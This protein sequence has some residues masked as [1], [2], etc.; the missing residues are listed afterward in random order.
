MKRIVFY[1][2]DLDGHCAGALAYRH[3]K[4][5]KDIDI[6]LI[7]INYG[8]SFPWNKIDED[9][10]VWMVDFCL[11][12]FDQM[13]RLKEEAGDL[14]WID[15]H[16]KGSIIDAD[17]AGLRDPALKKYDKQRSLKEACSMAT[18]VHETTY[19]YIKGLQL[20]GNNEGGFSGCELTWIYCFPYKPMPEF[21]HLLGYYDVWQVDD[22]AK[23]K[24]ALEL[25]FGM[26]LADS[27]PELPIWDDLLEDDR[28]ESRSMNKIMLSS[29][30]DTGK[31]VLRYKAQQDKIYIRVC[32][33]RT[34]MDGL[35]LLAVNRMLTNSQLFESSEHD[36]PDVDAWC[37][38]GWR[39][40]Q[41][42]VSL[43][44]DW[45]GIDLSEVCAK[46]GGGGHPN[47]SGFQCDS[48]PFALPTKGGSALPVKGGGV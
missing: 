22:A 20:I 3:L 36:H 2:T 37:A 43:Y 41:W 45:D 47:A 44:K 21:V 16:T 15:H 33:F 10:E 29:F 5:L 25:Q 14:Y 23:R 8:H 7:G 46:Y 27:F 32:G 26:R 6:E 17:E 4:K 19:P 31:L 1:H 11:Q 34:E 13:I 48:L 30:I 35:K 42:H 28:D 40:G 18:R 9:T 12:P 39:R 24:K 38:F